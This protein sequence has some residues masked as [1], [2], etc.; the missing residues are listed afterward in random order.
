MVPEAQPKQDKLKAALPVHS[1]HVLN[2]GRNLTEQGA[3]MLD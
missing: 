2:A 1:T 3:L